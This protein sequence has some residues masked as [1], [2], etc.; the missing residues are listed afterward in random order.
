MHGV[1]LSAAKNLDTCSDVGP[2]EQVSRF[3]AALRMTRDFRVRFS[4]VTK[5]GVTHVVPHPVLLWRPERQFTPL[6]FRHRE[7]RLPAG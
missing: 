7:I 3:F 6:L 4:I 1:I 2:L 5:F